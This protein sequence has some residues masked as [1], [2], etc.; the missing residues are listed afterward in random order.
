MKARLGH[1]II[2]ASLSIIDSYSVIHSGFAET[3]SLWFSP[4]RL[5]TDRADLPLGNANIFNIRLGKD[6]AHPVHYA[7][8]IDLSARLLPVNNPE[9]IHISPNI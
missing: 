8:G 5:D 7:S 2:N 4:F 1:Q 6:Y 3:L 9:D